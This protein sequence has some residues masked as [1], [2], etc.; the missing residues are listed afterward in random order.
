ML[1][2]EA[3]GI[4]LYYKYPGGE[5]ADSSWPDCVLVEICNEEVAFY[6]SGDESRYYMRGM[7]VLGV[8]ITRRS[9]KIR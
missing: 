6:R 4:V 5:V 7:P 2:L 8:E 1:K 9:K 3:D